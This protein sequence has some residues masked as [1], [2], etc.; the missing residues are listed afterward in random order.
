MELKKH[1]WLQEPIE[2]YPNKQIEQVYHEANQFTDA[3]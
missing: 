3:L 2:C 1:T